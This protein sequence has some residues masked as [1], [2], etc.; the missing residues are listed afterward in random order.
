M[1]KLP[2]L[3]YNLTMEPRYDHTKHEKEIYQ[4]WEESGAFTPKIDKS[5]KPFTI[6]MPPPNAN[7]PLHIG[8]ARFVAIE[9]ILIRYHRMKGDPTLWLPGS[10]HAG[11]ETQFVFEKRLKEI[12]KSRFDYDRE[13][14]YKMIWEYV[15]KNT[16]IMHNQLR[17]LGASCDWTRHKFT[18]D[19][20]IIKIVYATFKK[21]ADDGLV[22]RGERIVN[23]CPRC[24]TA[25]SQLE[26]DYVERDDNLYFLNYGSVSIATTRPE[27][28]FGDVAVAVN[29]KD[30]R[31]EKLIGTSVQPPLKL[32]RTPNDDKPPF[33]ATIPL[34]NRVIPI[35][36]D[37]L[38]D[39]D[40]GTGAVKITPAHDAMDFEI[41]Q[42]HK[43]QT[44]SVIDDAGRLTNTPEKY[45]G[46]K[47]EKAREEVV[48]DLE[49][50]GK[51]KKIEKIHHTV[52][53]CYR[54]HGVI[55][56]KVSKQWFL[57]VEPLTKMA[58][59]AI[60]DKYVKFVA[61]QYEKIAIHWL[62]NLRDWNISRQI[63]WGIRIPAFRCEKCLEWNITDGSNPEKCISCGNDKLTQ[64]SDTFDTW[65]SSGQWPYATLLSSSKSK[66]KKQKS[67]LPVGI[68]TTEDFEYFYPNSLMETAYE[69]LPFWVIRMIMLG[70]YATDKVPFREVLIH[71]LVRDREGQKISKSKGNVID[72]IAMVDKYGSDA[73]RMGLIWG[74]LVE[75]D[76]TLDEQKIAGQRNFANKIWNVARFVFSNETGA[77]S[78]KL[79]AQS[80]DDKWIKAELKKTT[81]KVTK[82]LDTY[83]LNEAAEEIYEFVWHKFADI[84]LEKTK[85]RRADAQKTLEL[86]LKDSLKL[87]HPFM[88]FVTETIWQQLSSSKDSTLLISASWPK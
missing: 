12:G 61:K 72:P 4:K 27:T 36:A 53:T 28:I 65:F 42:K 23:Y 68:S 16:E 29:P 24:G 62:K 3:D 41:G 80:E 18:L 31:Y 54:D 84:Y 57:K 10:D 33:Y 5:K 38:V 13:T 35:I 14:L 2:D 59:K 30:K 81:K 32:R 46:L 74:A 48:K 47:V 76:I 39:M 55:E 8:H 77:K 44:V 56:P 9:D 40:F 88:P 6:I 26:V 19:P 82:M 86:V 69:I 73:L 71:G 17:A 43:L 49:A 25:F 37:P 45:I 64:D 52:G 70:L 34:I 51:I 50:A 1:A 78:L 87:L 85:D 83:K 79:K 11:I 15:E 58:L 66:S 7:D 60:K 21:L 67:K 20:E 22:Y 63:V 75:R